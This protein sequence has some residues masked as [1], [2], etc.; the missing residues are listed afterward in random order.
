MKN[1]IIVT[2]LLT[3]KEGQ[4]EQVLAALK[5]VQEASRKETGCII[6]NLHKTVEGNTF[7]LYEEWANAEAMEEH[8]HSDHYLEYRAAISDRV[9]DRQVFKLE[10]ID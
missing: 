6:Y 1:S 4:E 8:I 9:S 7:V 2:A 5:R 3:P 10:A